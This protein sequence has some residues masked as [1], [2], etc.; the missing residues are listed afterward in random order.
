MRLWSIHPKYLDNIGLVALWREWILAR[1]VLEGK[2]RGYRNHPQLLK[3]KNYEKPLD[4]ID[5]YLYQIYLE[6]NNRRYYFNISKIRVIELYGVSKVTRGQLIFEFNHLLKK[7]EK[8]NRK[9]FEK[10]KNLDP[11]EIESNPV[12]QIVEGN[13]EYWEK[14]PNKR[15]RNN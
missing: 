3:F 8:R 12:F 1:R 5:A 10:L 15:G 14:S 6:A 9:W 4:L 7:L 11:K 13:V 2:T